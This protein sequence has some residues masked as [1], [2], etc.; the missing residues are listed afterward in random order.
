M[1]PELKTAAPCYGNFM[2]RVAE[3]V[4]QIHTGA[5]T[6]YEMIKPFFNRGIISDA[7]RKARAS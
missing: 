7:E 2:N 3:G 4:E 1:L 6:P 5:L